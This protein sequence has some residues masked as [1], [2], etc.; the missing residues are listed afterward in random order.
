MNINSKIRSYNWV[1]GE[2]LSLKFITI[3]KGFFKCLFLPE[4][5]SSALEDKELVFQNEKFSL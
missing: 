1:L 3:F 2:G 4:A 5:S